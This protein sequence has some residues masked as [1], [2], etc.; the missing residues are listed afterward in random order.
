[1]TTD[2]GIMPTTSPTAKNLEAI[3]RALDQHKANCGLPVLEIRLNP[4]EVDRLG[5]DD[6][7]GIP[8]TEDPG[9]GTGRFS[10]VCEGDHAP[11][12]SAEIEHVEAVAAPE[13]VLA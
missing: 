10:L 13:P 5:F 3:S 6:F 8:I 4:F 7:L 11:A 9:I 2:K 12:E 1:M